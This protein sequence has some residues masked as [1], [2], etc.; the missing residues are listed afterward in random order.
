MTVHDAGATGIFRSSAG[1]ATALAGFSVAD[2]AGAVGASGTFVFAVVAAG[3]VF[4]VSVALSVAAAVF[5]EL[6][7]RLTLQAHVAKARAQSAPVS[8]CIL[9]IV[10]SPD[11]CLFRETPTRR[12]ALVSLTNTNDNQDGNPQR[13]L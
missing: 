10:G 7:V 8:R 5:V 3:S 12:T 6:G 2:G 1:T 4:L 9:F 13:R 11:L